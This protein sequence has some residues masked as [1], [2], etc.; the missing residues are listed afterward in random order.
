MPN[1]DQTIA[2]IVEFNN[3]D[4]PFTYEIS[5]NKIIGKWNITNSRWF[6]PGS[7]TDII[8]KYSFTITL[9]EASG[10]FSTTETKQESSIKFG[11]NSDGNIGL[12]GNDSMF[13]GSMS[14]KSFQVGVGGE[15]DGSNGVGINTIKFDTKLIKE[16]V[17][18]T[19][20]SLGWKKKGV[21]GNLFG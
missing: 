1:S 16:P 10:K 6:A 21:F 15:K 2:K 14:Q 17:L 19:L 18:S 13:M 5:G 20:S 9:D 4:Q 8:Q 3:Q 12:T 11:I 7:I